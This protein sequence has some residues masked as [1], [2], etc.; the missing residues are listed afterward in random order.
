MAGIGREV[1]DAYVTIHADTSRLERQI[2]NAARRAGTTAGKQMDNAF[3]RELSDMGVKM[4]RRLQADAQKGGKNSGVKFGD[5]FRKAVERRMKRLDLDF[6]GNFAD[7]DFDRIAKKYG[8]IGEAVQVTRE[9][10]E[11]LRKENR[12]TNQEWKDG[13]GVLADWERRARSARKEMDWSEAI[14][15][16]ERFHR[17][18][19]EQRDAFRDIQVEQEGIIERNDRLRESREAAFTNKIIKAHTQA[20]KENAQWEERRAAVAREIDLEQQGLNDRYLVRLEETRRKQEVLARKEHEEREKL[21]KQR[22]RDHLEHFNL[23]GKLS[24]RTRA[25]VVAVL[26]SMDQIAVLGSF[27]GSSLTAMLGSVVMASGALLSLG[28]VAIG[29]GYGLALAATSFDKMKESVPGATEA[30]ENFSRVFK[31]V[32]GATFAKEWGPALTTFVNTLADSLEFDQ[33]A[34][35][36]GQAFAGIT[37]AFTGVLNGGL[38]GNFITA[39]EGPLAR[40]LESFG[41]GFAL[42]SEAMLGLFAAGGP[43]ALVLGERF[44]ALGDRFSAF[45]ERAS[46][47]GTLTEFFDL[48]LE[49]MAAVNGFLGPLSRALGNVFRL[50]ADTGNGMLNVLGDLATTFLEWTQSIEGQNSLA[51]WFERGREIFDAFL[52]FVGNLSQAL[53]NLV[54]PETTAHFIGFLDTFGEFLPIFGDFFAAFGELGLLELLAQ[55]LLTIGKA[56]EPLIPLFGDLMNL[57]GDAVMDLLRDLT[58][59]LVTLGEAFAEALEPVIPLIEEILDGILPLI[60]VLV[61]S[62]LPAVVDLVPAFVD[63]IEA[64]EPL[65]PIIVDDLMPAFLDLVEAIV[66]LIPI[67]IEELLPAVIDFIENGLDVLVEL[68]PYVVGAME[69]LADAMPGIIEN[70]TPVLEGLGSFLEF[71]A[72]GP[73]DFD[74][75]AGL[76]RLREDLEGLPAAL[77]GVWQSLHDG[78]NEGMAWLGSVFTDISKPWVDFYYWILDLFGIASPSKF[79]EGIGKALLDGIVVGLAGLWDAIT[80]PWTPI[81]AFF[82][83]IPAKVGTAL[84]SLASTLS[85]TFSTAWGG[86]KTAA[87]EKI[88]EILTLGRNLPDRIKTAIGSLRT[89][90]YTK[91]SDLIGGLIGGITLRLS[92]IATTIKTAISN[93]KLPSISL[94]SIN[95]PSINVPWGASGMVVN[96]AQVVGVGEAGPEAIVPLNRPLSQVDPSV[97]ALSAFAQGLSTDSGQARQQVVI[98]AGAISI[99]TPVTDPALVARMVLDQVAHAVGR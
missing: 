98:Q 74:F 56:I 16:N 41:T 91:G 44:R 92:E 37:D 68:M 9:R 36:L 79:M 57:L 95:L 75:H 23:L 20:L 40:A 96:G 39:M 52:P 88:E 24:K 77:D 59:S 65:I 1:A 50:G 10:L 87:S 12:L 69:G 32:D 45:I 85:T 27:V 31:D 4:R 67:I 47:D 6:I 42:V 89:T 33:V 53:N 35:R 93:I 90:L 71:M 84:S 99:T 5:E 43:A 81:L 3:D 18:L 72:N 25:I 94:P 38:W 70:L 21:R 62:L 80:A 58:P 66:P 61:A 26:A 2:R 13:L 60:P 15:E 29:A 97:R 34:E 46:A 82:T 76:D 64:L 17:T 48:A 73:D 11:E 55:V 83:E 14:K 22:R 8:G 19:M 63:L 28:G 49:S 7:G 86:A 30:F 51:E 78:W 54:T